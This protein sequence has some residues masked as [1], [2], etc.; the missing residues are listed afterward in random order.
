MKFLLDHDFEQ[1]LRIDQIGEMKKVGKWHCAKE[2]TY[3]ELTM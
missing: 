1:T 2:A 3:L